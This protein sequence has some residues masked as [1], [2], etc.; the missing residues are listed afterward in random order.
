MNK[1]KH[2]LLFEAFNARTI[3]KTISYLDKEVGKK[4]REKFISSLRDLKDR[5]DLP[6]DKIDDSYFDYLSK[7]DALEVRTNQMVDNPDGIYCLKFWFSTTKG[8]TG[9]T[10]TGNV[11][12]K[13]VEQR[14]S[15]SGRSESI[16]IKDLNDAG[17]TS[18]TI[19]TLGN[20]LRELNTG[21]Q[22]VGIF[23]SEWEKPF[24]LATAFVTRN[25]RGEPT[26]YYAIQDTCSGSNPDVR[27]DNEWRVY[28]RYSWNIG[29]SSGT[30]QSDNHK[31]GKYTNDGSKLNVD[32]VDV[33]DVTKKEV[34]ITE[35][36]MEFN[37]PMSGKAARSWW[38]DSYNSID[39]DSFEKSDFAIILYYDKLYD[40]A[41]MGKSPSSIKRKRE[42]EKSG[43]YALL[44][45]ESIKRENINRYMDA[46]CKGLGLDYE[47]ELSPRNLQKLITKLL[48]GRL[49]LYFIGY[50]EAN[51]RVN[52]IIQDITYLVNEYN[53]QPKPL[54]GRGKERVKERY[55]ILSNRIKDYYNDPTYTASRD[56]SNRLLEKLKKN[57]KEDEY[58]IFERILL[59]GDHINNS[60]LSNP[61]NTLED[62]RLVHI[63]I[64][65]IAT[66]MNNDYLALTRSM[67]DTLENLIYDEDNSYYYLCR[68]KEGE[69]FEKANA[70]VDLIER[71]VKSIL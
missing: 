63:K 58:K 68:I 42:Q 48:N 71:Y 10:Y 19:T 30:R 44:D 20:S 37:L 9:H 36:P 41:V 65:S 5:Y 16:D 4:E 18:G 38:T 32:G 29:S 14:R 66:V 43:A 54:S 8:F 53:D 7:K 40:S 50:K 34:V 12:K 31:L 56:A 49:S 67:R 62:M 11:I 52:R 3:S 13:K 6:I 46:L 27:N 25:S 35:N 39:L 61:I 22:I 15:P 55:D 45:N 2:I 70:R 47:N 23:S 1:N 59:I 64:N 57:G 60:L 21:D 51:S 17:I 33:F 26:G 24:Q 69:G 28:G